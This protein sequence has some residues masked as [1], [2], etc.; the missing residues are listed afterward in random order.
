M[1]QNCRPSAMFWFGHDA[2][3]SSFPAKNL[4]GNQWSGLKTP[5]L[6]S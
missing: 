4:T 2:N 1:T 3:L 5:V 6:L